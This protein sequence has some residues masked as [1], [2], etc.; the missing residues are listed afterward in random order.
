MKN[1]FTIRLREGRGLIGQIN[2][3]FYEDSEDMVSVALG[4]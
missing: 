4:Y 2:V 3:N 1:D